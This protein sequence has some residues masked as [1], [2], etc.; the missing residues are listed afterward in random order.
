[1]T[2][3]AKLAPRKFSVGILNMASGSRPG[4]GFESGAGAQEENLHRRSD[5][6]RF[7][8]QKRFLYPIPR[9]GCLLSTNVTIFRGTEQDG[10]PFLQAPFHATIISCAAIKYPVLDAG[11]NYIHSSDVEVMR[12]KISV[13]LGAA[14]KSGC[15]AVILSAFG[16]GA[17]ANPPRIV[18]KLFAEELRHVPLKEVVFCIIDDHNSGS[19]HNPKREC[20]IL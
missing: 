13:I 11:M 9:K 14:V 1:M 12:T 7:L 3:A 15:D 10:Y 18:V 6:Y 4:G 19:Y 5:M 8:Q 20:T 17:F 2:E 16:C